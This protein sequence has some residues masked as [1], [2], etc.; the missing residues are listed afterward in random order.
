LHAFTSSLLLDN[1]SFSTQTR[2]P[3][4]A[5]LDVDPEAEQLFAEAT[6][7]QTGLLPSLG[8]LDEA[9]SFIAAERV[10][11]TAARASANNLNGDVGGASGSRERLGR[12][13]DGDNDGLRQQE[14]EDWRDAIG[15][16]PLNLIQ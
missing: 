3:A 9:L 14:G 2:F 10:R 11:L 7:S 4:E 12:E 1:N 6:S 15:K 8:Y 5:G 13:S 16:F